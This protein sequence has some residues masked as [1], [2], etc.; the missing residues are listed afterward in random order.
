MVVIT[1]HTSADSFNNSYATSRYS[2]YGVSGTPDVKLDGNYDVLG[3]IHTGTM[4]PVYRD[5][6]DT[7][8]TVPSPIGI[9]L[10]V[11]YDSTTRQG[12]LSVTL[13][14]PGNSA[15]SGQLQVALVERSKYCLWQGLDSVYTVERTMLPNANGEAVTIPANDS[16]A[17]TRSFTLNPGWVDRKCDLVVFVQNNST[18]EIYQGARTAIRPT[19]GVA[20]LKYEPVLPLPGNDVP[21]AIHL[22]SVGTGGA[23][24]VNAT[25]STSDPNITVTTPTAS[26]GAIPRGEERGPATNFQIHVSNSCPDPHLATMNL[27]ITGDNGYASTTSFPMNVASVTGFVDN[28]ENGT[29]NWTHE[30]T[31]D[32]WHQSTYR[33]VSPSHSWYSGTES[34]H[35]YTNENDAR[36]ITPYFTFGAGST[37]NYQNWYASEATFD[38]CIVEV[39]NGS[40]FWSPIATY[41]G[42]GTT[43]QAQSFPLDAYANQTTR[44]RFRF[45]SD[46]NVTAEGWYI[47]DFS[48]G[49]ATGIAEE[50]AVALTGRLAVGSPV[51]DRVEIRY[52]VPAGRGFLRAYDVRGRE[53]REVASGLS[54]AGSVSWNLTDNAGNRVSLG[55]YFVQLALEGRPLVSKVVVT[56]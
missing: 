14:N 42:T 6:F 43:W 40:D 2:F 12:Q 41:T 11:A 4:Y 20:Y 46:Y 44:V 47:D 34:N 22:R 7:R 19:P 16:L 9:A 52:Q 36:L 33:S 32:Q 51:R 39:N 35:Q 38:Y 30:G 53:V 13:R 56:K 25:L 27:S 48:A 24:N 15:V 1:Y 50:K 37:L 31:G 54:G 10:V 3:G 17:R 29:N 49:T 18:K 45:L 28:M 26:Y 8:K 21:L 55:T 5:H 23:E